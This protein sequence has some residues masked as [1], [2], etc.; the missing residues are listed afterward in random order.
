MKKITIYVH[1][2]IPGAT[3]NAISKLTNFLW[4]NNM[5]V[6]NIKQEIINNELEAL[7]FETDKKGKVIK[8]NCLREDEENA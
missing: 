2:E 6:V 7:D 3:E 8:E 1:D 5:E 4:D